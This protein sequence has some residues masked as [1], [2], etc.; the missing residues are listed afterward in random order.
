VEQVLAV[1]GEQLERKYQLQARGIDENP[2]IEIVARVTDV[3]PLQVC[4]AGKER[5]RFRAGNRFCYWAVRDLG[6]T[7]TA[8]SG[9]LYLSPV[10]VSLAVKRGEEIAR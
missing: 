9:K 1:A 4:S 3:K 6:V 5:V 7:M 10:G 8:R 2:L